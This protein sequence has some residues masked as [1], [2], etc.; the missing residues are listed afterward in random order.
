M[1]QPVVEK[2]KTHI[3]CPVNYI[4][5]ENCGVNEIMWKNIVEPGRPQ[6][7]IWRMHIACCLHIDPGYVILI[8]FPLQ[9]LLHKRASILCYSTRTL[10]DLLL[11]Q[12]AT[13]HLFVIILL[14]H[15]NPLN[16]ELSPTCQLL[17]L[18]GA[19]HIL[20]VSRIRVNFVIHQSSCHWSLCNARY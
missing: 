4:F 1:F 16:A 12:S 15:F 18:L 14:S 11:S 6:M 8:A 13:V 2:I 10:P 9:Q 17:A 7:T 20:H 19:H 3:L 5:F